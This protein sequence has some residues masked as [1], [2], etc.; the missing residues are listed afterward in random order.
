MSRDFFKAA[1]VDDFHQ[2]CPLQEVMEWWVG[3]SFALLSQLFHYLS[4][5]MPQLFAHCHSFD[6]YRPLLHCLLC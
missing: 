4:I 2:A 5:A 1:S 6:I 3:G